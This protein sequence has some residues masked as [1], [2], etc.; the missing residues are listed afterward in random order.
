M[1]DPSQTAKEILDLARC[2]D[3]GEYEDK[4]Y[5]QLV[6]AGLAGRMNQE[7]NY[8]AE[9]NAELV[10]KHL[11]GATVLDFGCGDAKTAKFLES[12][13]YQINLADVYQHSSVKESKLPFYLLSD[14]K[15]NTDGQFDNTLVLTVLHH[16]DRPLETLDETIR[17]TKK[18][19]RV[20]VIESVYGIDFPDGSG[21]NE[22]SREQQ[23]QAA[24]FI[25]HWGNRILIDP[26]EKINLPYNY[27]TAE[28]WKEVFEER[29]L[30]EIHM[31]HLGIDLPFLPEY[32]TLHVC[33]V[34]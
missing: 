34:R 22:L 13:G 7:L 1:P 4:L 10:R 15:I 23:I 18:G 17:V 31:E 30:A 5:N 2:C 28:K 20:I 11:R 14:G 12:S 21:F 27:L 29:G 3:E 33:E 9:H 32:H 6:E 19:G 16:C 26:R 8:R 24:A 25:D